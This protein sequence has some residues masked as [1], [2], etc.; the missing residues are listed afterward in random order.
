M[1]LTQ[2]R[3]LLGVGGGLLAALVLGVAAFVGLM[4]DWG[5]RPLCHKQIMLAFRQWLHDERSETFPN[6]GGASG[7]S[8]SAL[9]Q[10]LADSTVETKYRYVAGLRSDDPGDL[11]LMYLAA[12]T[13][14]RWHGRPRTRLAPKGWLVLP[15][16]FGCDPGRTPVVPGECSE[17]LSEREFAYRPRATLDFLLTNR[18]PHCET[19]MAEHAAV[20]TALGRHG[21]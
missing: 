17:W 11:V 21:N 9:R 8:L 12:P 14:W 5:E 6:L 3:W 13:R 7:L 18:R 20:P 1:R 4:L 15:V 10:N 16:D 19:V 2:R